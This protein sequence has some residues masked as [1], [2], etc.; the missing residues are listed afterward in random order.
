MPL[1]EFHS[2]K[3]IPQNKKRQ[4]N[5]SLVKE[6]WKHEAMGGIYEVGHTKSHM[7]W[8]SPERVRTHSTDASFTY[9]TV[10]LTP[11]QRGH[12]LSLSRLRSGAGAGVFHQTRHLLRPVFQ[13]HTHPGRG[14]MLSLSS[15]IRAR[16]CDRSRLQAKHTNKG[17]TLYSCTAVKISVDRRLNIRGI[18]A[19]MWI[20]QM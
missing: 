7:W 5:R 13:Q 2:L 3:D 14:L 1:F 19:A 17:E 20:W 8:G 12:T 15:L 18:Q 6:V 4:N 9:H 16:D 11:N 10:S